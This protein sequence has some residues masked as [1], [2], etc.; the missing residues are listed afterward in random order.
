MGSL[1]LL[2]Q[3]VAFDIGEGFAVEVDL[4]QVAAAVIQIVDAAAVGQGGSGAVAVGVD[5][6]GQ[7]EAVVEAVGFCAVG[8][9]C[10][11]DRH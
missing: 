2:M 9:G 10:F 3:P 8:Y 6:V 4:V 5:A 11:S 1:N 7:F